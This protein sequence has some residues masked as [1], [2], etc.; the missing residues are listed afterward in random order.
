RWWELAQRFSDVIASAAKRSPW[1]R[2]LLR[3]FAPRNDRKVLQSR[4][5]LNITAPCLAMVFILLAEETQGRIDRGRHALA[6]RAETGPRHPPRDAIQQRQVLHPPAAGQDAV[7]RLPQPHRPFAAG[8][9]LAARLVAA[10]LHAS[11][12][13]LQPAGGD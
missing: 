8:R 12:R 3:R 5:C 7:Q 1:T 6:Q 4:Q 2:R 9:A 13:D 10:D 11:P